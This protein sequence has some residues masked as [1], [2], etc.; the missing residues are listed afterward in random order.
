MYAAETLFIFTEVFRGFP[1]TPQTNSEIVL[2]FSTRSLPSK[3][4]A[5]KHSP[6]S[7]PLDAL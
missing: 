1:Q 2:R 5:V 4:F 7:V 6:L 3:S